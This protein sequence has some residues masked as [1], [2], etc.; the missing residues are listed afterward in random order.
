[1][2]HNTSLTFKIVVVEW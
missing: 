1:L 2:N